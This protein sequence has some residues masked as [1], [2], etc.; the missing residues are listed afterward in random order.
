[1]EFSHHLKPATISNA[2]K[3]LSGGK[4]L[5]AVLRKNDTGIKRRSPDS[6]SSSDATDRPHGVHGRQNS[7]IFLH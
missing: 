7:N 4:V 1:M 5:E 6:E 3:G 2:G